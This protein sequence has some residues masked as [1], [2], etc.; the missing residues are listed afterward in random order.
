MDMAVPG[1][2]ARQGRLQQAAHEGPPPAAAS[3]ACGGNKTAF[4]ST[5]SKVWIHTTE[6]S[7]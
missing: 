7:I 4:Q 6:S 2:T 1:G 3:D 5:S